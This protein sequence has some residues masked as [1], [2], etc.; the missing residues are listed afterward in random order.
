MKYVYENVLEA[1]S[2][3]GIV[4]MA[5]GNGGFEIYYDPI[6]EAISNAESIPLGIGLEW[7]DDGD[8]SFHIHE[9]FVRT[10]H[11]STTAEQ[12]DSVDYEQVIHCLEDMNEKKGIYKFYFDEKLRN[13]IPE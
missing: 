12:R 11:F 8:V 1:W 7:N 10:G 6:N 5:I 9:K 3:Y 13:L 2:M 4:I